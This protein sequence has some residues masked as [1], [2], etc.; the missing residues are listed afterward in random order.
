[1]NVCIGKHIFITLLKDETVHD[2]EEN[3]QNNSLSFEMS[4]ESVLEL[5]GKEDDC[6][7]FQNTTLKR[8]SL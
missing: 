4:N 5:A 7:N 1:M 2:Q 6:R 8:S 3:G